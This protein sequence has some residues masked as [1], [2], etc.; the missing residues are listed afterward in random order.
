MLRHQLKIHHQT[1]SVQTSLQ[2]FDNFML[3]L[4][5]YFQLFYF[6]K[7]IEG[8]VPGLHL[9]SKAWDEIS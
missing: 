1:S 7:Y 9:E 5:G 8:I 6:E 4:S 3:L 2:T